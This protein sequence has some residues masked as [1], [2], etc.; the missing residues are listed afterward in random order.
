[1]ALGAPDAQTPDVP[2]LQDRGPV[3][4][5]AAAYVCRNLTCQAPLTEPKGCG[6]T[7]S[8]DDLALCQSKVTRNQRLAPNIDVWLP[9]RIRL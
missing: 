1:V 2:L 7:L 5:Q 9:G 6:S 4:G 8:S 3:E